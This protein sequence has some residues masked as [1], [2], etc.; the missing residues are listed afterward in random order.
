MEEAYCWVEE[1]HSDHCIVMVN[2]NGQESLFRVPFALGEDGDVAGIGQPEEMEKDYVPKRQPMPMQMG[3]MT[4]TTKTYVAELAERTRDLHE[5]RTK[6]GRVISTA[7]RA[8][9][10]E[11]LDAMAT[12]SDVIQN[13][14]RASEPPAKAD[15]ELWR[16]RAR[17]FA[18]SAGFYLD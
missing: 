14:M 4:E 18:L 16:R 13:L 1:T 6:E 7:N 5:R 9:L 3:M 17:Q 2:R 8:S 15:E 10:Q 12:A 11:C